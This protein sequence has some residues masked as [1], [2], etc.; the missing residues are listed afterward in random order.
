[1]SPAN[2]Q[3]FARRRVTRNRN[4]LTVILP[5]PF[6]YAMQLRRGEVLELRLFVE[7]YGFRMRAVRDV[8]REDIVAWPDLGE[9]VC[10]RRLTRYGNGLS[11]AVPRHFW[12]ALYVFQHDL[13]E[14][15]LADNRLSIWVQPVRP[16]RTRPAPTSDLIN[17]SEG[18][19]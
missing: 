5:R 16:R 2:G 1:V 14:L 8:P 18:S 11:V 4:S 7:E 3:R 15:L 13:I 9:N 6:L 12:H 17:V 10:Q 19:K